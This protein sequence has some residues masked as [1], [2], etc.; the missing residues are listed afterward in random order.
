LIRET[1]NYASIELD[2][3]PAAQRIEKRMRFCA[4]QALES[5]KNIEGYFRRSKG[6][7]YRCC[8]NPHASQ[9]EEDSFPAHIS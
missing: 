4:Y 9:D 2:K 1:K 3:I 8:C 6:S 7:C 5:S